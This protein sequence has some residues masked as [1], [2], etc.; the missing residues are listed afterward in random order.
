MHSWRKYALAILLVVIIIQ[1]VYI[2]APRPAKIE[3]NSAQKPYYE[4]LDLK[5]L[6]AMRLSGTGVKI[7]FLDTGID[8]NHSGLPKS[9]IYAWKDFVGDKNGVVHSTPYDDNGHGTGVIFVAA[10]SGVKI[11]NDSL[12][13]FGIAWNASI[14]VAK[15]LNYANKVIPTDC[16][17]LV[18]AMDWAWKDA[19]ANIVNISIQCFTE[20]RDGTNQVSQKVDEL[21]AAGVIVITIA[22][23]EGWRKPNTETITVPG[24][25]KGAVTVGA[26]DTR[27]LHIWINSSNGPTRDGRLKPDIVAP[28]ENLLTA[29]INNTMAKTNGTSFS[30]A[31][32]SGIA[33]LLL[34]RNMN[35][36]PQNLKKI[37][38]SSATDLGE[39]GPD[40]TFGFGL[41]NASKA[42][43]AL[44]SG[45]L[46]TATQIVSSIEPWLASASL[47]LAV[48]A[49]VLYIKDRLRASPRIVQTFARIM[50]SGDYQISGVLTNT[51]NRTA[52]H[53]SV[54]LQDQ[55]ESQF[56]R[57]LTFQP[58]DSPIGKLRP[59][60]PSHEEFRLLPSTQIVV[61]CYL[62]PPEI[63]KEVQLVLYSKDKAVDA[64]PV[65]VPRRQTAEEGV[66]SLIT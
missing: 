65:F 26:T 46:A 39:V 29:Y 41:V 20:P 61:R 1:F 43:D 58:I 13:L 25:S 36:A 44:G 3:Y 19:H 37:L 56:A 4:A 9:R 18:E 51:G 28:G 40:T 50:D 34:E 45:G 33:A 54:W 8:L 10:G 48:I 5:P 57:Q 63:D 32:V 27:G 2:V 59:E 17:K 11:G 38:I 64:S 16:S 24:D 53:C 66:Y 35:L 6:H 15:V 7:A 23:N 12:P 31:I 49:L 52:N 42:Y 21:V 14:A 62:K 47:V 30:A 55:P 60:W 22:G